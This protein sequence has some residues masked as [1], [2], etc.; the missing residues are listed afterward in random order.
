MLFA[1]LTIDSDRRDADRRETASTG[2]VTVLR[3]EVGY[4]IPAGQDMRVESAVGLRARGLGGRT[5][6]VGT[7]EGTVPA[8]LD[9]FGGGV[10]GGVGA[11]GGGVL[12]S[13]SATAGRSIAYTRPP[14]TPTPIVVAP[15]PQPPR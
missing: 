10:G 4:A 7:R 5:F 6:D 15:A 3:T 8:Q 12:R 1:L 11:V 9:R 13:R 14:P 2:A